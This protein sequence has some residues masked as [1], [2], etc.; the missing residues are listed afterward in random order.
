MEVYLTFDDGI[1][2][3]TEEVLAILK[4]MG[5]K[6]TFFL[7]GMQVFYA[8]RRNSTACLRVLKEICEEHAIGNHSFSHANFFYADYYREDGPRLNDRGER[9]SIRM[10]FDKNRSVLN[11]YL[12][13]IYNKNGEERNGLLARGQKKQLARLP[14]RNSWYLPAGTVTNTGQPYFH[15][16]EGTQRPAK[17]LFEDGYHLYGWNAEWCMSFEFHKEAVSRIKEAQQEGRLNYHDKDSIHPDF[18]M[19]DA[20]HLEK[21]RLIEGWEDVGQR[22]LTL[23]T[24]NSVVLLMHD[25][26]FRKSAAPDFTRDARQLKSLILFLKENNAVFKTLDHFTG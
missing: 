25:R 10:D 16:E 2:P 23:G 20:Q 7:V 19:Y 4:E 5:V 15:C 8:Y 26:A 11:H 6:A 14:G 1:Q 12:G 17:T 24:H 3:G 18:D 22:V 21:D 13:I 9:M